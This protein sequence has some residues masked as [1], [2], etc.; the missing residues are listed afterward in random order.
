MLPMRMIR[1]LG[2]IFLAAAISAASG[3]Q[4]ALADPAA[5]PP[6]APAPAATP[7][8]VAPEPRAPESRFTW[9]PFGYLRAQYIAVQDDPGVAFV[10]RDDGFQ[11]QNARIGVRGELDRRVAFVIAFDGAIDE[12][13][14]V[15]T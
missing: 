6:D 9:Q 10:G 15:N 2:A 13:T 12:R 1:V 11:M 5:D 4:A 3:P 14:Q 7:L 8:P